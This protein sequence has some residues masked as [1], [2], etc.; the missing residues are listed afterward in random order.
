MEAGNVGQRWGERG[1]SLGG[2]QRG[3]GPSAGGRQALSACGSFDDRAGGDVGRAVG[4]TGDRALG[5]KLSREALAELG[6]NLEFCAVALRGRVPAPSVWSEL[7][8]A[9]D[10]GA[11]ER[12]LG[13]WVK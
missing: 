13:A 8:R 10:V 3:P 12:L 11:L 4:S 2:V 7:F 6:R 1:R 9:L 5:R